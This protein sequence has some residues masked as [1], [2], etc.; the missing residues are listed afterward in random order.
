MGEP[1]V[2]AETV[3]KL[4]YILDREDEAEE[5]IDFYEEEINTIKDKTVGLSE[6][7]KPLVYIETGKS[8]WGLFA[9]CVNVR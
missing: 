3:R 8:P 1:E 6:D 7:E 5:L 4:G 2:F 9:K